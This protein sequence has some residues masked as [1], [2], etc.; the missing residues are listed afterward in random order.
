MTP[1][2]P[3]VTQG[4][5]PAG[6]ELPLIGMGA[7]HPL[8]LNPHKGCTEAATFT[9]CPPDFGDTQPT[10][11]A[12]KRRRVHDGVTHERLENWDEEEVAAVTQSSLSRPP[13]PALLVLGCWTG[14]RGEQSRLGCSEDAVQHPAVFYGIFFCFCALQSMFQHDRGNEFLLYRNYSISAD[15]D[16]S[17]ITPTE[18][19]YKPGA[20]K[21][22]WFLAEE[23]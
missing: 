3:R 1:V 14:P 16:L 11:R 9:P 7:P 19:F 10:Q 23:N 20:L 6:A 2:T 18:G 12:A 17:V 22:V 8:A 4:G 21:G 5:R 13:L 15:K